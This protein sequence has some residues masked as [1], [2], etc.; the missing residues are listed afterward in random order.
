MVFST[1]HS[2][3]LALGEL[4]GHSAGGPP[5]LGQVLTLS[6]FVVH[7]NISVTTTAVPLHENQITALNVMMYEAQ[8]PISRNQ[9]SR[10]CCSKLAATQR[11]TWCKGL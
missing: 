5:P 1:F 6:C 10:A 9:Q 7:F 3:T 2:K 11:E 4:A 8:S